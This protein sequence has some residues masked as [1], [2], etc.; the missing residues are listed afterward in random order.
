M[1]LVDVDDVG[2]DV[3]G[4]PKGILR[5]FAIPTHQFL[6]HTDIG[7]VLKSLPTSRDIGAE[8]YYTIYDDLQGTS[9]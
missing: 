2:R 6:S 5:S 1:R 9:S 7:K 4:L 3:K 8:P